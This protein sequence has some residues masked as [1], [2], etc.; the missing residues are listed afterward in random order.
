[1]SLTG[2]VAAHPAQ[3]SK[4]IIAALASMI[5]AGSHVH[6]PYAGLGLR[7]GALCDELGA[8]FTGTDIEA[9]PDADSR[10]VVGDAR[11]PASYPAGRFIVV[12][13]PPY[14]GNRISTDY[15]NGPLPTTKTAGRRS[16]GISLGRALHADNLARL[17]REKHRRDFYENFAAA[18]QWWPEALLNVDLPMKDDTLD[19]LLAAGLSACTLLPVET[20]RYRVAGHGDERPPHELVIHAERTP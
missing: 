10:V 19:A 14:F 20:P 8:T 12:T 2:A 11:D 15:A 5:P 16:Y 1:M 3:F 6:D 17:G 9:W 18:A 7:L 4:S 13:S